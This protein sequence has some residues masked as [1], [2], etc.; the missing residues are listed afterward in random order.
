MRAMKISLAQYRKPRPKTGQGRL[1]KVAKGKND[2][3]LSRTGSSGSS[4]TRSRALNDPVS[5]PMPD[6]LSG[7]LSRAVRSLTRK[8]YQALR[9]CAADLGTDDFNDR[10]VR[11]LG[12]R[13][14]ETGE[15]GHENPDFPS[16]RRA[17][18]RA[19]RQADRVCRIP[20][21]PYHA[22][23]HY[24]RRH[25]SHIGGS[26]TKS[27]DASAPP[28][29]RCGGEANRRCRTKSHGSPCAFHFDQHFGGWLKAVARKWKDSDQPARTPRSPVLHSRLACRATLIAYEDLEEPFFILLR[30]MGFWDKEKQTLTS[31]PDYTTVTATA[32]IQPGKF[33][34]RFVKHQPPG[35]LDPRS[36][37]LKTGGM[38]G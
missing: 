10:P 28:S 5:I 8:L 32:V 23:S 18:V 19:V 14:S 2:P 3:G 37:K 35:N 13:A 24:R 12:R 21:S 15:Q 27:R 26:E 16:I 1:R 7:V 34:R 31:S 11:E 22:T 6:P 25:A 38:N 30:P 20:N 36:N 33:A 4:V 29:T 9:D 17:Q